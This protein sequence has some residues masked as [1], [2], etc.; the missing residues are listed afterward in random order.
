LQDKILGSLLGL[1][2]GDALGA[3]IEFE[4]RDSYT[5]I[6]QMRAGGPFNLQIGQWTD[7]TSLALCMAASLIEKKQFNP[8][9]ITKRFYEWF[10]NGYMSCTGHCFDIG[11]TTKAALMRF[12]ESGGYFAG[13]TNDPASNGSLM[14]LAPIPIFFHDDLDKTLFFAAESSRLTHAPLICVDACKALA[15]L[16]HRALNGKSKK[17]ILDFKSDDL[18]VCPEIELILLGSYKN[19]TREE[20]SAKGLATTCLEAALWAF[21]HSL[22]FN[23]GV[24]LAVNLGEDSDTTGAVFGQLAGAFYGA[25]NI[26]ADFLENLWQRELIESM[27]LN[28]RSNRFFYCGENPTV[29]LIIINPEKKVLVIRRSSQSN[30]CPGMLAFPGGFIDSKA[31]QGSFWQNDWETPKE[32]AIRELAEE[33][34][35]VLSKET[36][37]ILVGEYVGNNR[38]PRDSAVAW[39]KTFAFLYVIDHDLYEKEK[40]NIRGQDDADL[41]LWIAIEEL[42]QMK[43]A[44]DHNQILEDACA[45]I[46][47][48]LS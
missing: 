21:Y 37:L 45:F 30:A 43:L 6:T 26:R 42:R 1:A 16:I 31:L 13:S 10:K 7:D 22:N 14:R 5:P 20:I 28:L 24:L 2:V 27:A 4:T 3:P 8:E 25:K 34:N 36:E 32:A 33:T 17:E 35:L 41:A 46:S 9:D 29:D 15:L 12:E 39:S 40:S 18:K 48:P 23:D 38:D 44:F 47:K 19:K 11:N